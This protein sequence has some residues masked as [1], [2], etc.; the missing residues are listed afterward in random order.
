LNGTTSPVRGGRRRAICRSG[1]F[2]SVY[3]QAFNFTTRQ[4]ALLRGR[5]LSL[6]VRAVSTSLQTT[7]AVP[8][9]ERTL[10][11]ESQVGLLV[12]IHLLLWTWVGIS[13][14][15]NFDAPGDMVEAYTWAQGWQWGYYKH[16]PLSAWVAGLWFAVVPASHWGYSLLAAL[17][18][19]IGLLGLAVLAREFL[20]KPWV[21]LAVAVASLAPGIT[22]LAMRFNANAILVSTWP[23]AVALFVRLMQR[24]QARDAVLCGAVAALAMLGKYYSAVML[25][26]LLATALWVPAW[27]TRLL[28]AP[29]GLALAT[30]AIGFTPHALW[31]LSQVH[32]PL[33]YAQ[34]ATGQEGHGASVMRACSFALAQ[35]V[36]PLL[37][38]LALR[39]ALVG[40]ARHRGFFQAALAPLRPRGDALWLL[41]V[42]PV[43]ATM[44]ATVITSARTASVWGLAIAFGLA[45]LAASR[46]RESGAVLS[47]P[48]LWRTLAVIW[49][50]V[51]VL[52]PIWWQA[53][54]SMATPAVAEPR[55]ELGHTAERIWRREVGTPLPW[56][57]GTR[58]LAASVAFYAADHPGYWSLW[59][60]SIETPWVDE[61][62]IHAHGG[63]IV[64]DT[65]DLECQS[66]A[67][68]WTADR[69]RIAVSKFERGFQFEPVPY[70]FYLVPPLAAA[71]H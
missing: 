52:S 33:Q 26:S 16:P 18:S 61:N 1:A 65:A 22:T 63:V 6:R 46:A 17:N 23:W 58:A 30:F 15:S 27:R 31:L 38:F 66:R 56:V 19:A 8:A 50:L 20:P 45:L 3:I 2:T 14:R 68:A 64:C 29:F 53:R 11:I 39:L 67:E 60:N 40:P 4:S 69:R 28:T 5:V 21:L 55:E 35:C 44:L 62:Q 48:R 71:A 57:S 37:A 10:S 9:R 25:L 47:L 7:V 36:F 34:A 41:A 42:L 12:L 70:V 32:G 59:S 54:A 24:G 43:V 49:L 51:A 13:S